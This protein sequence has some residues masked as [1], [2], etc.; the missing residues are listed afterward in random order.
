[1]FRMSFVLKEK[2]DGTL[3]LVLPIWFRFLFL[4]IVLLLTAGVIVSGIG[5]SGQWVPILIILIC[6]VGALYEEKWIFDKSLNSFAYISG[7]VILNKKKTYKIKEIEIF[8]ITGEFHTENEGKIN[9]IRKKMV[10]FSMVLNSG[11]VLD[12]DITTGKTNSAELKEKAQKIAA[13]CGVEL[14]IGS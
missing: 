13:Y 1:M 5:A 2:R 8:N 7:T 3:V 14:A 10:K 9:R 12:I 6:I 4:F 11:K